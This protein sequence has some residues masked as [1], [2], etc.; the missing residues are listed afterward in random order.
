MGGKSGYFNLTNYSP[1]IICKKSFM[2][3]RLRGLS[4]PIKISR[5]SYYF[6]T[7]DEFA[8]MMCQKCRWRSL[9]RLGAD[10][11]CV[12][13]PYQ[14]SEEINSLVGSHRPSV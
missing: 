9:P 10:G 3:W 1:P 11:C 2:S 14:S 13:L 8:I 6:S 7:N 12:V 4:T 5:H